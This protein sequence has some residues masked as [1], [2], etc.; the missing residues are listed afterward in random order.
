MP[1]PPSMLRGGINLPQMTR[2]RLVFL[3]VAYLSLSRLHHRLP[4]GRRTWNDGG[5]SRGPAPDR[6]RPPAIGGFDL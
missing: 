5:H 4:R 2:T 1:C 3:I 6:G